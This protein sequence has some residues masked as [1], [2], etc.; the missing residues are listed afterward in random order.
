LLALSQEVKVLQNFSKNL[1][2][3]TR[4]LLVWAGRANHVRSSN[5]PTWEDVAPEKSRVYICAHSRSDAQRLIAEYTGAPAFPNEVRNFFS[6]EWDYKMKSVER[7]RGIWA[8][9]NHKD[10]D[11]KAVRLF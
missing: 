8:D 5:D 9:F 1:I 10:R 6:E 4:K 3:P 2:M 7:E 11:S